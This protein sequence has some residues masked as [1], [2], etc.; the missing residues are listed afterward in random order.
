MKKKKRQSQADMISEGIS[1]QTGDVKKE[2]GMPDPVRVLISRREGV[3]DR[4]WT[5]I[6]ERKCKQPRT[7]YGVPMRNHIYCSCLKS[8]V[9]LALKHASG[10]ASKVDTSA[11]FL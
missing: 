3:F 2:R 1:K 10:L 11:T 8:V 7:S 5:D 6:L 9:A 4:F